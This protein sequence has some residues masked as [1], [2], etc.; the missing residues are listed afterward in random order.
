MRQ[1]KINIIVRIT[2]IIIVYI[3]DF[4]KKHTQHNLHI[5]N[6]QIIHIHIHSSIFYM[7]VNKFRIMFTYLKSNNVHWW[8]ISVVCIKTRGQ[9][10]SLNRRSMLFQA[11]L[12]IDG[13]YWNWTRRE[14]RRII[15]TRLMFETKTDSYTY[16][17]YRL[18]A[19]ST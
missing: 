3:I 1:V 9:F 13:Q 18:D 10:H 4:Q 2:S 12:S 11:L 6:G 15:M 19:N 5:R 16:L 14:R 17:E 7:I 8:D